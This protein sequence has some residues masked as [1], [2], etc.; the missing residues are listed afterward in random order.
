MSSIN[1]ILYGNK[2]IEM[3]HLKKKKQACVNETEEYIYVFEWGR[4]KYMC[5]YVFDTNKMK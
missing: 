3:R 4:K 1:T 5:E 2:P